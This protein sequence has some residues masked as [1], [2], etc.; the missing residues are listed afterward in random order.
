MRTSELDCIEQEPA[1]PAHYSVILLHGAGGSNTEFLPLLPHFTPADTA[2][3]FVLPNA[4]WR[5]VTL[6]DKM[7]MRAWYDVVHAD[8]DT[9][10]DTAGILAAQQSL[11]DLMAREMSRGFPPERI[12]LGGF[13]QGGAIALYTTFTHPHRLAG[14]IALSAY[15][16]RAAACAASK[17]RCPGTPIYMAHG[18]ADTL[19]PAARAHSVARFLSSRGCP[20]HFATFPMEHATT[21]AEFASLKVWIDAT[22]HPGAPARAP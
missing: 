15:L 14:A 3:R 22:L 2:V 11:V 5:R 17:Q 1:T 20:V 21:P 7:R 4:P 9:E 6:F 10:E 19:V 13:S 16:P 8:L 12:L 18:S